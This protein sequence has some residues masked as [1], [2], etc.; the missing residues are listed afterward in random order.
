MK[1]YTITFHH[2]G[3]FKFHIG[4]ILSK[5]KLVLEKKNKTTGAKA[6]VVVSA[7]KPAVL[8]FDVKKRYLILRLHYELLNRNDV[9]CSF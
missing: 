3:T 7:E 9:L 6:I 5:E 2:L 4:H 1:G 8:Q